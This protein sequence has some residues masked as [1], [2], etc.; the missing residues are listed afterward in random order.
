MITK[1]FTFK[2]MEIIGI[3][4]HVMKTAAQITENF[5]RFSRICLLNQFNMNS[6]NIETVF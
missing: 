1:T 2:I 5:H 4:A 3:N 6:I